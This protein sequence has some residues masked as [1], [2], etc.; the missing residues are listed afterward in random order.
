[1]CAGMVFD[2]PKAFGIAMA[3]SFIGM[4]LQYW[5][6]RYVFKDKV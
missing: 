4:S 2:F 1:M 5:A 3:G 6:A